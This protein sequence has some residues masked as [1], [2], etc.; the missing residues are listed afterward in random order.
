MV[1]VCEVRRVRVKS[2][3]RPGLLQLHLRCPTSPDEVPMYLQPIPLEGEKVGSK[4]KV[5]MDASVLL[6]MYCT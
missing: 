5:L 4:D 3:R 2:V 1:H 6:Y